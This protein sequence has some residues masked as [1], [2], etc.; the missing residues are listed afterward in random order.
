MSTT[1]L[2][3]YL[4]FLREHRKKYAE[5]DKNVKNMTSK[6]GKRNGMR[7]RGREETRAKEESKR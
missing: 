3:G 4:A 6:I 7:E 5:E 2:H 1:R